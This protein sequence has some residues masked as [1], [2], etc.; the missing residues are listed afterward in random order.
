M[1]TRSASIPVTQ[2]LS[3]MRSL[4]YDVIYPKYYKHSNES[5]TFVVFRLQS[6]MISCTPYR[7]FFF[8]FKSKRSYMIFHVQNSLKVQ[9]E[10]KNKYVLHSH[11]N[12][13]K[14]LS[15]CQFSP[16]K[17]HVGTRTRTIK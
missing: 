3:V 2:K 12:C 9:I 10:F 4:P 13:I 17:L 1:M 14:I 6:L 16:C 15:E 11:L 7:D 8:L 5:G